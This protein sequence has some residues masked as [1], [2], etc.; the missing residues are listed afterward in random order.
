MM[1]T[2]GRYGM[3]T[4]ARGRISALAAT[5]AALGLMGLPGCRKASKPAPGGRAEQ[6]A[7]SGSPGKTAQDR[8]A[9]ARQVASTD[10]AAPASRPA[11][12]DRPAA[13]RTSTFYGAVPAPKAGPSVEGPGVS[14]WIAER[15]RRAKAGERELVR[16]PLAQRSM[17]WGCE[18]PMH[19]V[20]TSTG[21][22]TGHWVSLTVGS[23]LET[24]DTR[25]GWVR[26]A[27]GY[28]TGR[29]VTE[30]LRDKNKEPPEYLYHPW[31][32]HVLRSRAARDD[33]ESHSDAD[34]ATAVVLDAKHF[35]VP[36]PA[37]NDARPWLTIAQTIPLHQPNALATAQATVERLQRAG[38]PQAEFLDSRQA[39]ELFC[40]Y[41]LVVS[42]RHPTQAEAVRQAR[43]LKAKRFSAYARRGW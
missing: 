25:E 30:D 5:L 8:T 43:A 14:E 41:L 31:E 34:A 26:V 9:P 12:P 13:A 29:R 15:V 18:C 33:T 35:A 38:F 11:E 1:T 27:E 20:G 40:C 16:L 32:F 22:G 10:A 6:A 17:G 7:P 24:S 4:G 3:L 19:F 2:T 21:T 42:G 23:A 36:V 28:F 39:K 37:L